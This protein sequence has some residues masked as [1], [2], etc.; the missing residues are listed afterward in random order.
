M[1]PARVVHGGRVVADAVLVDGAHPDT[2][3]QGLQVEDPAGLHHLRRLRPARRERQH[4]GGGVGGELDEAV[5][6]LVETADELDAGLVRRRVDAGVL[7]DQAGHRGPA[8]FDL[9]LAAGGL[10]LL[11]G[12]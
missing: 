3:L 5:T 1:Q 8:P 12:E 11:P 2:A 4:L 7:G 9:L 6:H 10:G